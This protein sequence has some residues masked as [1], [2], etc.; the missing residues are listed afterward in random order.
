MLPVDNLDA[1]DA[2]GKE[3]VVDFPDWRVDRC[4]GILESSIAVV[5]VLCRMV[6]KVFFLPLPE[7][8]DKPA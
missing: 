5:T 1:G 7:G 8:E 4:H 2:P 3:A 6:V